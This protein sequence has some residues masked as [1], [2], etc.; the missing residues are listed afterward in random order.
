MSFGREGRYFFGMNEAESNARNRERTFSWPF[1]LVL[2]VLIAAA[3]G[4]VVFLRL[5][6][7]PART[8]KQGTAELERLA[9]DVRDA[10]VDVA[11][12]QP[13]VKINNRVYLEKT[14]AVA[15]VAVVS[16][17]I[18][19]E[20]ELMH[21]WAGSTK[22]VKLHGTFAVK[23]GFD[24]R[25]DITVDLLPDAI[26][27]RMPPAKILGVEQQLIDVLA[28][29]NGFWNRISAADLEGELAVMPDL[30]RQKAGE[31]DLAG[32]AQREVQRQLTE[33][34]H[35][36]RPLHLTFASAAPKN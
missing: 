10:F 23:A 36:K 24:L 11:Q 25:E 9:H 15:E 22:R 33:R 5:E 28:F 14:I 21:T 16:R 1:A 32:E 18:E 4:T 12:L 6:S 20:H 3:V 8:A 2:I 29:E 26:A 31:S 17:Q 7:W 19:V 13:R 35:A 30:A 27:V 34:I